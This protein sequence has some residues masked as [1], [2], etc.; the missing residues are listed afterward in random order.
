[1]NKQGPLARYEAL[2]ADGSIAKDPAQEAAA[3]KL[4]WLHDQLLDYRPPQAKTGWTAKLGFARRKPTNPPKG[5]YIYGSV[6]RGKSML[7][8]LFFEGAQVE[9]KR[10]IHFHEF[11]RE[12]HELI[13]QWRQ[14]NKVSRTA[15]PIRPTAQKLADSAWLLCFDEFEVRDIADA[16]IVSRLF[17]AMFELG[18][19]VVATSNRAPDELYKDGLQRDLFLPFIGILKARHE[20]FHL[21]DG[22]DYR[23]GRLRGK[24]VYHV[25]S[26]PEA[27]AALDETFADLT[28][29]EPEPDVIERKGRKIHVPAA[30]AGVAR[31]GFRD[32]CDQP[33]AAADFLAVAERFH[34]VILS[35]IPVLGAANRDQAR[36]F[37]TLIDALYDQG[38]RLIASAEATPEK[39]YDGEDWGFEFD[40]TI[41]RLM[42]MQS[43]D[44]F[45][46]RRR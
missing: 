25:P 14:E 37:M 18:V 23:L 7:M 43:L 44:Y 24:T 11:M 4:Q 41:S 40:R 1:M 22:E 2:V 36:R 20:V 28:D 42:E 38:V 13:H 15:E 8:D 30:A 29:A 9:R 27:D 46:S 10:R 31:F 39:L 21:D 6:G 19:V 16:M 35:D 33:L 17:F 32:L 12:A 45:E 3:A 26:G 34:T 5:L